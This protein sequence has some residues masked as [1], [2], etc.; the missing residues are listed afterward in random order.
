MMERRHEVIFSEQEEAIF[1]HLKTANEL[2]AMISQPRA[3][4]RG[5]FLSHIRVLQGLITL[6]G[7]RRTGVNWLG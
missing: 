3:G 5:E 2:Y 1:K 7:V 4:E 6:R